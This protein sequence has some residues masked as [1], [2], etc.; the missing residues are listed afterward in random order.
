MS[1]RRSQFNLFIKH[2]LIGGITILL[3]IVIL[4]LFIRWLYSTLSSFIEPLTSILVSSL[5]LSR[6]EANILLVLALIFV[7]FLLGNFVSTRAGDW[8]WQRAD[9]WMT[10]HIPG[11]R[12][13]S[14]LVEQL[15]GDKNNS[16][17]RRGE[18]A[19]LWLH[20]R[21]KPISV[22]GI[23]TARHAN[24][25]VTVFVPCGPNPTTGFI[26]HVDASLVDV[27]PAIKVEQLMKMAVAC[28]AGSQ[29]ILKNS[30][31]CPEP[32]PPQAPPNH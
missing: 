17:T 3:P 26:Y 18:V 1:S 4:L 14:N 25:M 9:A 23:I 30:L 10:K 2:S 8:L 24:G 21:D 16:A 27:C 29:A 6:L 13:V 15:M 19:N 31:N 20:G 28:G 7:C 11:Y 22:T 32:N 12:L 5:G